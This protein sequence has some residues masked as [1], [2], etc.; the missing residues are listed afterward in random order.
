MKERIK[1]ISII[2]AATVLL[3]AGF[4]YADTWTAAPEDPPG[5][6][7]LAP[8]NVGVSGGPGQ[9]K[10]DPLTLNGLPTALTANGVINAKS[11]MLV[12][13]QFNI[14]TANAGPDKI[15]TSL[16]SQGTT[17]W[18]TSDEIGLGGGGGTVSVT[19]CKYY[20]N[21][22]TYDFDGTWVFHDEGDGND[23]AWTCRNGVLTGV[24]AGASNFAW[25]GARENEYL[26]DSGSLALSNAST[27]STYH[28]N[29]GGYTFWYGMLTVKNNSNKDATLTRTSFNPIASE[30]APTSFVVL[31]SQSAY[32]TFGTL[33]PSSPCSPTIDPLFFNGTGSATYNVVQDGVVVDTVTYSW[34]FSN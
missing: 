19:S 6:N 13:G 17:A 23:L 3:V 34:T 20:L 18:K 26:C 10:E 27:V 14:K 21:G 9:T 24:C 5:G 22:A 8:I 16:D 4:S 28:C 25:R 7:V 33:G 30:G 2:A 32:P 31:A 1:S 12:E 11:G 29:V 15:L